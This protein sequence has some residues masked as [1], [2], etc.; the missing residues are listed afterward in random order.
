MKK[1]ELRQMIREVLKEEL[2]ATREKALKESTVPA[3]SAIIQ[4]YDNNVTDHIV[5]LEHERAFA[6]AAYFEEEWYELKDV[7]VDPDYYMLIMDKPVKDSD[8]ELIISYAFDVLVDVADAMSEGGIVQDASSN[9]I[10]VE[11]WVVE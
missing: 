4:R 8:V 1:S 10:Y 9:E 2:S 6:D 7:T 3:A 5:E 11:R